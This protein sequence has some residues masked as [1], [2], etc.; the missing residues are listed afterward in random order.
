[1]RT[2]QNLDRRSIRKNLVLTLLG[3]SIGTLAWAQQSVAI[4]DTQT[5]ASAVL[6]L[7]AVNSNQGLIIPVV[8][9]RNSIA[10]SGAESGMIVF[11]KSDNKLYYHNGS[12]WVE[13]GGSSNGTPVTLTPGQNITITG[14]FPNFTI[15]A[16]NVDP[17]I[18]NEVTQVNARGGLEITG[19][20]TAAS[21]LT[22]GLI[23]GT[24]EGQILT[25]D[26]T[27]KKWVLSAAPG[28]TGTVTS[29]ATG[30]G[31]TGGPVTTSGTISLANTAVTPGTYGSAT[32]ASQ[33]T[34]DAQGRITAAS[35]NT[36][37]DAS[38]TNEIQN[39]TFTGTG[40]ATAGENFPLNISSG[41]GVTIKEGTNV[42][43]TQA[44]N[45]LTINAGSAAGVTSV[46]S[47]TGLT[48]GPITTTGTL[49][50]ANTAVTPGVYGSASAIPAITVDAQGR[51][52]AAST[53]TVADASA[54][55]EIQNLSF[56]GTGSAAAG[57]TFPLNISAGGTG[58]SIQEG[59]NVSI[60]Q[61]ANVLTINSAAG[62]TSVA[63]G[64]GLTGGPITGTG[65]ISLANTAVTPGTYGNATNIP[66][67]IVDAQGRIT[68]ATAVP[69]TTGGW[70]TAGNAGIN[71]FNEFIGTTDARIFA[72]RTNN[73]PRIQ[74]GA[75]G[76]IS[77]SGASGTQITMGGTTTADEAINADGAISSISNRAASNGVKGVN[78]DI[79]VTQ[80]GGRVGGAFYAQSSG[81][82]I[83]YGAQGVANG[84]GTK[85]GVYGSAQNTGTNYAIY[86]DAVGGTTNWAGYFGNG[87]VAITNGLAVGAGQN[88]GTAGQVLTSAG[89]GVAPTWST[90]S[91]STFSTLNVIPK[92]DGTAGQIASLIYDNG[93][94]V[95]IG[96]TTPTKKLDLAGDLNL[97][98]GSSIFVN[99]IRVFNNTGNSNTFLGNNAGLVQTGNHNTFLGFETGLDNTTGTYNLFVGR[100]AGTTNTT[101]SY[102]VYVGAD[103]GFNMATG[104]LNTF[105]GFNAG[106]NAVAVTSGTFL[107]N[108]AGENTTG[109]F[110]TFVGERA[111]QTTS[112]GTENTMVG[113]T[114][115]ATNV[116][117]GRITLLGHG[118]DVGADGLTNATAIGYNA[119]VDAS[120]TV[121]LGAGADVGIGNSNPGVEAGATRYL[122]V[123]AGTSPSSG[124]G[125]V[126]IQGGSGTIGNPI[127][128]MDFISNSSP[129][130]VAIGRIEARTAGSAQFKGD[131]VFYT[132]TGSPFA[133][134]ALVEQMRIT[135][136]GLIGMGRTPT[137]NDLEVEGT[138]SKTTASSWAANSDA[139]IKTDIQDVTDGIQTIKRLRPVKFK[140]TPYWMAKHPS[141]KNQYY[142]NYIAQEYQE[143]FPN[144]VKGSGEYIE[145]D[146]KEILQVDTYD[147]QIV[148]VK[149]MQE[150]IEKVELLE[151]E[152]QKLR[153]EKENAVNELRAEIEQIKK[154]LMMEASNDQ[155]K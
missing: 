128:R 100:G 114:T 152:N 140:Y 122:T 62:V 49:S 148:M 14:S 131:M 38:A 71:E 82:D 55:N 28:G 141:I 138:A 19:S 57:E 91:G 88:F 67:I 135:D 33:I 56:T 2:P 15:A 25:W 12:A 43:I 116:T 75:T 113:R 133:S 60:S 18:G 93:T 112:T 51:I 110:N 143:V 30:T 80:I 84:T 86:G 78:A 123:A 150:L 125:A 92:G 127:A 1:M 31:L 6:Y 29:V 97:S 145:G 124:I 27:A 61:A 146:N 37:P 47:G 5:K 83:K 44:A 142:Y 66:Q 155:K 102:N 149:A 121:V 89:P 134:S 8:S 50:L 126:E 23:Q 120:N 76:I 154:I 45:V 65:T 22:V 105:L 54:T 147:T 77:I 104:S 117:G 16:P 139:R 85:Y 34:V 41:T 115:G 3:L 58:V 26:N 119:S 52:T 99:G 42:S 64:T 70:N 20:G 109:S 35:S 7:K 96:T 40:S 72:V 90:V 59:T 130:N 98:T 94:N 101:G 106:K 144:A 4:G 48:G 68:S 32:A 137:A 17:T 53:N 129:G 108:K 46:A 63:S 10:G 81:A 118:A 69:I 153:T 11:D 74:V 132:R 24:T 36:F 9:T 136:D 39:L 95:G 107:G 103:A 111:G 21:P 87:H 73:V 13:A 151:K 79:G